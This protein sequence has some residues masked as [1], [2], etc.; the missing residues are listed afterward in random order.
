MLYN[1]KYLKQTSAELLH[2][3]NVYAYIDCAGKS[4]YFPL[5]CSNTIGN[6]FTK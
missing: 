5:K 3:Y 1:L 4:T 2:L 6:K